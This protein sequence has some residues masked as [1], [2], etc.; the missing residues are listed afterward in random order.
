MSHREGRHLPQQFGGIRLEFGDFAGDY[1]AVLPCDGQGGSLLREVV[2]LE[3]FEDNTIENLGQELLGCPAIQS[4]DAAALITCTRGEV[5]TLVRRI[6]NASMGRDISPRRTKNVNE[7]QVAVMQWK[8][9]L[10]E[11][12]SKF[13]EVVADSGNE[14]HASQRH[15]RAIPRWTVPL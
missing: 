8:V 12:E 13:S 5:A 10:V 11:H 7:L 15:I 1:A 9:T 4:S 2:K 6:L 14:S 3:K